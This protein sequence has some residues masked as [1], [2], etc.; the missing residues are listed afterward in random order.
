MMGQ[1]ARAIVSVLALG[2]AGE[3]EKP[4]RA[5][6][7][8]PNLVFILAD[9]LGWT[10]LG[11]FGS[12]YYKTP[13]IDRL[14]RQGRKFTDAYSCGPN[15]QPTR[16]ALM[17]GQYGPRTGIYTV[18]STRRF[19]T[20]ERPLVPVQNVT[21]LDPGITTVAESL[22][23]AGYATGMFGKWH[24]GED[25]EHHPSAQGFDEA[26]VSMGRHFDFKTNPKVEVDKNAYLADFLTDQSVDFLK[27][28]KSEKFFL[29]LPHFAVHSPFEAKK[30]EIAKFQGQPPAGGHH[31]PTYA[32]MI[33]SLDQSVGRVLETLDN[34]GLADNTVVIFSSDN[35]GVGGYKALGL[36][37]NG[38]TDNAPLRGGKG[39]LYEGGIRVPFIA[40]WPGHIPSGTTCD[41][42]ILSVD[43][44]PTLVDL[45]GGS[46]PKNQ[47]ADGQSLV[48]CLTTAGECDLPRD[49]LYWHFPGFLGQGKNHWRTT[50]AGAIRQGDYKLIEFFEDGHTELYNL[51]DDI[52]EQ[53]DLSSKM[54]EKARDL[55][56]KLVSWR[57]SINAPMP[58]KRT[59]SD[60]KNAEVPQKQLAD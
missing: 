57:E 48:P 41:E 40:R 24:L 28:H 18:G 16:A 39:M 22:K 56:Q 60:P 49:A 35:G 50:P 2:Q 5:D 23:K 55:H 26:I 38:I 44:Y 21:T 46:M 47:A 12:G 8:R 58:R 7:D 30:D 10:D 19:D 9:D 13:N 45:A 15:C 1:L 29:Y 6:S 11:C 20:H 43:L 34:L 53:H 37:R 33:A 52:G 27:R 59:A 25:A 32:A 54:P 17:S 42:P 4:A 14:A 3:A 31:D 36:P 51:R